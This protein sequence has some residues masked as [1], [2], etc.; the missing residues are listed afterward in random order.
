M[1]LTHKLLFLWLLVIHFA[2]FVSL[3]IINAIIIAKHPR[4]VC[5][6]N[7]NTILIRMEYLCV[8]DTSD[9]KCRDGY[10]L[11]DNRST[12]IFNHCFYN[13]GGCEHGCNGIIGLCTGD[14]WPNLK[15]TCLSYVCKH[16]YIENAGYQQVCVPDSGKCQCKFDYDMEADLSSC[17]FNYCFGKRWVWSILQ[18]A[19]RHVLVRYRL[20]HASWSILCIQQLLLWQR[21]LCADL[22]PRCRNMH[23]WEWVWAWIGRKVMSWHW[24]TVHHM[25]CTHSRTPSRW[26]LDA[27]S[28]R[29][30]RSDIG[31]YLRAG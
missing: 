10:Q 23:L 2:I 12:R 11:A 9:C 18:S 14:E 13:Y 3:I 20:R 16:C 6:C 19:L 4:G 25:P 30:I 17:I 8:P 1:Q 28:F 15:P 24:T 26:A 29:I 22:L 7:R 21:R 5:R 31:R 27:K